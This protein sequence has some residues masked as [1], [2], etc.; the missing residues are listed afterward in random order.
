MTHNPNNP[1]DDLSGTPDINPATGLPML[2]DAWIDVGGSP[3]GQDIHQPTWTP[4]VP[5]YDSWQ[6]SWDGF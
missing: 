6:P 2:N 5:T 1:L 3:Y 4:P